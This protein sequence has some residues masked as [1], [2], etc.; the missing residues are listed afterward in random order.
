MISQPAALQVQALRISYGKR[1]V[2][3]GV[4]LVVNAGEIF[5][6]LGPNGA[7]KTTLIRS[8]C[9]RCKPDAGQI[10][11]AGKVGRGRDVRRQ[12]GLVPQEIALYPHLT[13]RENLLVFGRLMGLSAAEAKAAVV[14]ASAATHIEARLADQVGIL[15]GGWKRRVNIAAAILHR[16]ALLILDEPTV[17]VDVEARNHLHEVI[18]ELAGAGMGVLLATHDLDQ[19]ETICSRVG[20]LRGGVIGP[21]GATRALVDE[22]FQGRQQII[23]ELRRAPTPEQIDFLNQR[24]FEPVQAA[25]IWSRMSGATPIPAADL[26]KW[27]AN[28]GIETRELRLREPG[29]DSLFLH[30]S[31]Q[32]QAVPGAAA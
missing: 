18:A 7:G 13:A 5:G 1:Q 6:L 12:I 17:G 16:P 31:R 15:S 21:Q 4:D 10:S 3:N 20:F 19:A 11:I 2:L 24:G 25:M 28:A 30:L 27:L 26:A 22:V 14:W 29:L 9:G 32:G 8:I 23:V